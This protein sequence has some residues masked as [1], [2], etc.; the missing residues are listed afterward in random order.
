MASQQQRE[1]KQRIY[2]E[3]KEK[4][5][6]VACR[7]RKPIKDRTLCGECADKKNSS[8]I[9]YRKLCQ[10]IGCKKFI[11]MGPRRYCDDCDTKDNSKQ[12]IYHRNNMRRIRSENK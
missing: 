8:K 6:C 2:E 1:V 11:E 5:I 3:M 4:E 9:R 7:Q 12:R 10:G